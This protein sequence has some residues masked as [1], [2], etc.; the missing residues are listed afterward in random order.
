[1]KKRSFS[2]LA[3]IAFSLA[4]AVGFLI[5]VAYGSYGVLNGTMT[6]GSVV[7]IIRLVNQLRTPAVNVTGIIPAFYNMI[8]SAQR[9]IEVNRRFPSTR[10]RG[11]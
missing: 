10:R 9:L 3:S 11:L 1:M 8:S 2:I 5:A 7:A 6:F 4:F